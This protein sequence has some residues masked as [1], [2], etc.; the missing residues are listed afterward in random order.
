MHAKNLTVA[1]VLL[2]APAC[3]D[4]PKECFTPTVSAATCDPARTTFSLVTTNPYFPLRPGNVSI[5]E[6]TDGGV[7]VRVERRVLG[8]TETVMGVR[9]RVL[10]VRELRDGQLREVA[11]NYYAEAVD[12]TVC[13]FG[14]DVDEYE[15]GE[16]ASH[17]GSWRAGVH[18]AKPGIAMPASPKVGDVYFQEVAPGVA[19][20]QG[21][22]TAVG[23][24]MT[25]AGMSYTD[26]VTIGDADPLDGGA[27]AE[28]TKHYAPGVGEVADGVTTLV[29]FTP[30]MDPP[31]PE[32]RRGEL[33]GGVR[34]GQR[35]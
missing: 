9:A 6:G 29:S 30:G 35:R 34:L 22:V 13:H 3:G 17:D 28:Q 7:P 23:G 8:E 19:Q 24:T 33:R 15:N 32:T 20:H 14:E 18:D 10:E 4:D 12:G 27:C 21:R 26:V 11:R 2:A 5:L 31:D 16:V 1:A 25:F